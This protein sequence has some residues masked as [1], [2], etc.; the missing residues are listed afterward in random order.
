MQSRNE[1]PI[2]FPVIFRSL[3]KPPVQGVKVDF[4]DK[5]RSNRSTNFEKIPRTTAEKCYRLILVGDQG[6]YSIYMPDVVLVRCAIRRFT[7]FRITLMSQLGVTIDG[8]V[9]APLQLFADR[10]FAGAG[11]AFNQII[12]NGHC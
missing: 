5:T 4:K 1:F 12:S 10:S 11:N 3:V 8:I 9:A 6:F 2:R 7:S